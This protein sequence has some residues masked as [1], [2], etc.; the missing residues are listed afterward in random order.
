MSGQGA[1]TGHELVSRTEAVWSAIERSH[2]IAEFDLRGYLRS[3]ND[4]FLDLFGYERDVLVGQHHRRLCAAVDANSPEYRQF[5]A[6][7]VDGDF[8]NRRCRRIASDGREVWIQ[9]SYN[10]V[11]G[12]DGRPVRIVKI[13]TDIGR[14]VGM[15]RELRTKVHNEAAMQEQL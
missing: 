5:W 2:A 8:Q 11:L 3:A 14:E 1:S 13:A 9:A 10:P 6:A 4:N 15:E 7:L 12:E